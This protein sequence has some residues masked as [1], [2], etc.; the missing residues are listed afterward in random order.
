M[1]A[2]RLSG[3]FCVP[4]DLSRDRLIMDSRPPNS[5]EIGLNR[6]TQCAA[7]GFLL[8]G[9]ELAPDQQLLCSGQDVKDFYYQFVVS[10]RRAAR[11]A[12]V[13]RLSASEM[14]EVFG[15]D[16]PGAATG[17]FVGLCYGHGGHLCL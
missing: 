9:I 4:K 12:L 1:D 6:W 17:G 10:R 13:G 8:A 14:I 7:S 5:A 3:L 16:C 15:A 11:N 2:D